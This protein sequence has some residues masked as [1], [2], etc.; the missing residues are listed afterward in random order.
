MEEYEELSLEEED[1][2]S[3]E[4]EQILADKQVHAPSDLSSQSV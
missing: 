4:I 2:F 1:P 3:P